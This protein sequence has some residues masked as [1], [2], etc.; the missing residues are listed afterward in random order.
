[1]NV[2]R[3]TM[4]LVSLCIALRAQDAIQGM[5]SYTYGDNESLVEAKQ[6]VKEL[7]LRDAVESYYLFIESTTTVENA[8]V[9]EDLI[10]SIAA[11]IL[12][13]IKIEDQI[14]EGRTITMTVSAKVQGDAVRELVQSRMEAQPDDS[15]S[16]VRS[17]RDDADFFQDMDRLENRM[18]PQAAGG[19]GTN[20]PNTLQ[21]RRRLLEDLDR[22]RP[23]AENAFQHAVF[24]CTR[25][26]LQVEDAMDRLR[27]FRS[28]D[29]TVQIKKQADILKNLSRNLK[30]QTDALQSFGGL[31]EENRKIRD[32]WV[33]RCRETLAR[34]RRISSAVRR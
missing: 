28:S 11:G 21:E 29:K 8:Q 20:I 33:K 2:I 19:A 23:P 10:R 25:Q 1:M 4:V 13:D 6:T 32:I 16:A 30:V 22:R 31:S 17:P 27:H 18:P 15:S 26:R 7:A 5:Y 9:K 14:V 34:V 3:T 24:L 12:T